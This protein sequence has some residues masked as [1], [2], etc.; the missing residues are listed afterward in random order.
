MCDLLE[1][2]KMTLE[3]DLHRA[4]DRIE[5]LEILQANI[6]TDIQTAIEKAFAKVGLIKSGD[7]S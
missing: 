5:Q 7:Q 1:Q 4:N 2:D 3:D 6:A